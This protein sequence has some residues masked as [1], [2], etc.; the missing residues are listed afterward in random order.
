MA[1]S[2]PLNV[3]ELVE[4]CISFLH[5]PR[6]L[7]SCALVSRRWVYAAQSYLFRAPDIT[8][9]LSTPEILWHLFL[10][11]LASSPHLI[12]YI[13]RLHI[14]LDPGRL[15]HVAT[16]SRICGFHF[17]N[18]ETVVL[19]LYGDGL[20]ASAVTALQQLFG[21]PTVRRIRLHCT[22]RD[23]KAFTHLWDR[24]SPGLKEVVLAC[25]SDDQSMTSDSF[26]SITFLPTST[27]KPALESLYMLSNQML[28]YR[29]IENAC[30]FDLSKLK[31]LCIGWRARVP[32][33]FFTPVVRSIETLDLVVNGTTASL[34][35][36][37]FPKLTSLRLC[38][39]YWMPAQK[40]Q[41]L[42]DQLCSGIGSANV[43]R[44]LVISPHRHG[45]MDGALCMLLDSKLSN[46]PM[47]HQAGVELEMDQDDYEGIWLFFP[48]LNS[49]NKLR[50]TDT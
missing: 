43:I 25:D 33:P 14:E 32:W 20:P 50:R 17:P 1:Q 23:A 5:S 18:L 15:Q 6:D 29:L 8:S 46:L 22:L 39:P 11:T 41:L 28:D 13:R 36:S 4:N 40:M 47:P 45:Q 10:E 7:K 49:M 37:S 35:L 9:V 26:N 34:V 24:C 21:L 19:I 48:R 27:P 12:P 3:E 16:L 44:K 31:L 42:I 2:N 30:P 38:L